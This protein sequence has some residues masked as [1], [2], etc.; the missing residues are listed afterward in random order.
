MIVEDCH[1]N[2]A[3]KSVTKICHQKCHQNLDRKT[4]AVVHFSIVRGAGPRHEDLIRALSRLEAPRPVRSAERR[5]ES[6][7]EA[8]VRDRLFAESPET[9]GR[10]VK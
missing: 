2:M 5:L 6:T 1:Q 10:D 9:N 4:P 3:P 7:P 8:G